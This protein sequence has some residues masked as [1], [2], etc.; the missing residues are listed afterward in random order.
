MRNDKTFKKLEENWKKMEEAPFFNLPAVIAAQ[1]AAANG[2]RQSATNKQEELPR[3][4]R[5]SSGA[6][7]RFIKTYNREPL[8]TN[9]D[10]I[11][12]VG[13]F[14]NQLRPEAPFY[15]NSK[16]EIAKEVIVTYWK[17]K[18]MTGKI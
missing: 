16:N 4:D 7:Q 10:D 13:T 8:Q 14:I 5:I 2:G 1:N 15:G 11:D 6:I 9:V 17:R 3:E 18:R 12:I